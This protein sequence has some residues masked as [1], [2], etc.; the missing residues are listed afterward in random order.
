MKIAVF[1]ICGTLYNSNTTFDFLSFYF[2]RNN[3]IK[4][5]LFKLCLSK[6]MKMFWKIF[7]LCGKQKTV[8]NFLIGFMENEP[9]SKVDTEAVLFVESYLEFRKITKVE[10][11]LNEKISDNYKII[12]TSASIEPVVKAIAK[13]HNVISVFFTELDKNKNTYT[14]KIKYDMEGQK[15]KAIE[16][17]KKNN[18]V[19]ETIFFTDN[20]EDIQLI[21]DS[22]HSSVVSKSKNLNYWKSKIGSKKHIDIIEID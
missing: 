4:F 18:R 1:D 3:R 19:E 15:H 17:F 5:F 21:F 10:L 16:G 11:L 6:F 20:K 8:R 2:K 7:S 14:G 12:F 13:K 9:V 22:N